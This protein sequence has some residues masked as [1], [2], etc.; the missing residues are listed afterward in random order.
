MNAMTGPDFTLYPFAT[1]NKT[2]FYNLLS[3]YLDA[4]FKPNLKHMDFR[5]EGWRLEHEDLDDPLSEIII[6]GTLFILRCL[7]CFYRN[8]LQV[9]PSLSKVWSSMR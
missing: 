2:D 6:K 3:V 7:L 1:Q 8:R 4:V 9:L 5:Q